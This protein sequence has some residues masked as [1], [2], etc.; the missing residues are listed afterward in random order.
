MNLANL[1]VK[2][3]AAM[4]TLILAVVAIVKLGPE[5]IRSKEQNAISWSTSLLA[6]LSQVEDRVKELEAAQLAD[7][8]VLEAALGYIM[9]LVRLWP[10]DAARIPQPHEA[11][12]P[13]LDGETLVELSE[14]LSEMGEARE[15][16]IEEFRQGEIDGV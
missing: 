13:H 11:L 14:A 3:Y 7:R 4:G 6:R 15:R 2:D 10:D 5:L 12:K 16:G 8:R 9:R 1:D